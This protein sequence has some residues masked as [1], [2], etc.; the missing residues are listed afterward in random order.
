MELTFSILCPWL[1]ESHALT[2]DLSASLFS[3]GKA[4]GF[5]EDDDDG[6]GVEGY[7]EVL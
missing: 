6:G 7:E 4:H 3:G 1:Y 5:T 2:S